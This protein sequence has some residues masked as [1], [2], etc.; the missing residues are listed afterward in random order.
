MGFDL[1][2]CNDL[3]EKGAEVKGIFSFAAAS[4]VRLGPS[5][6]SD[7]GKQDCGA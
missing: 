6:E 1:T 5:K 4:K 3:H 2:K 7:Q